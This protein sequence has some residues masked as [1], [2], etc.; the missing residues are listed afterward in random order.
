MILLSVQFGRISDFQYPVAG[1]IFGKSNPASVRRVP[2]P[3][4]K[5]VGLSD[6]PD[7]SYRTGIKNVNDTRKI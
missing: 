6:R 3:D 4:T 5:K 2:V 1:R 7:I